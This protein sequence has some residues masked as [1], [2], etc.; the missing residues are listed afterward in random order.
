VVVTWGIKLGV[1]FRGGSV[2]SVQFKNR[3]STEEVSKVLVATKLPA[4]K[5]LSVNPAGEE[6]MVI[7]SDTLS[8]PEHQAVIK[9]LQTAFKSGEPRETQF[10]SVGPAIGNELRSDSQTAIILTL[11]AVGAYIALVFRA[12][13]R[14][15]S[16]WV[17]SMAT[18][19]AMAHDILLPLGVFAFLSHYQ[20]VEISAVFVAAILTIMGYSISDTVVVFDRVRENVIKGR[21]G[22]DTNFGELVHR[23][24]MQTLVR[25]INTNVTVLI[26]LVAIYFFGGASIRYFSLALIIGIFSGA[27]SSIFVASPLLVWMSKRVGSKA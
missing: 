10:E 15:L 2:M 21:L 3:P 9:T 22:K 8:E 16:P 18:M 7:K 24:I 13:R 1:D 26:S 20:G 27:Y 11:L 23:S 14:T 25:S 17:M 4:F 5:D 19:V 6:G 12:M